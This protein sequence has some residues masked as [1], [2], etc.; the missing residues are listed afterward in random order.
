METPSFRCISW[1]TF[2]DEFDK[3]YL[4]KTLR[5]ILKKKEAKKRLI[6]KRKNSDLITPKIL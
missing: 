2:N 3:S 6:Q 1:N 5:M 4:F